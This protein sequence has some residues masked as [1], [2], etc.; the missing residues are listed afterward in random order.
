MLCLKAAGCSVLLVPPAQHT[1]GTVCSKI[2]YLLVFHS[3][4]EGRLFLNKIQQKSPVCTADGPQHSL[5]PAWG[6]RAPVGLQ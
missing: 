4:H 5:I 1:H 6:S 3:P 2:S